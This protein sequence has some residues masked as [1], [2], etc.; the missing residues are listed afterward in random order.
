M[1][2]SVNR[3]LAAT[4]MFVVLALP[5]VAAHA[6]ELT[7][8]TMGGD[9]PGWVKWLEAVA[10]NYEKAN[11]G[12]K[13]KITYY[14]KNALFTTLRTS[15]RA[16]QGPDVLYTEPDQVD[17]AAAG[18]L[19]PLETIAPWDKIQ[20]WAKDAWTSGGHAWAIPYSY[21]TNEI[22]YN[23]K[24][25]KE[26]GVTIP[27]NGQL[28]Q[29]QFLDLVKKAKAAG[30]EPIVIGAGDRPFTGAYLT[31]ELLLRKL[32]VADYGNL[33]NGKLSWSDP[34]VVQVLRYVK[35][36]VDA[37]ALPKT[38][39]TMNLTDSYQYFFK[40]KGLMFPQ[41]TWYT[42]RAFAPADRGG[43]PADFEVGVMTFPK[44]DGGA[45]DNCRHLAL[46]GGY[47]IAADT[48]KPDQAA[49]FLKAIATPEMG[50]LWTSLNNS[51]SGA[52]YDASKVTSP[53]SAYFVELDKVRGNSTYFI[54]IPN[55]HLTGGCRDAYVQVINKGFPAGLIGVD[56][57]IKEMNKACFK[58]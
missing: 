23:K 25:M 37:G 53:H 32:G 30:M 22:M 14:D 42:Q 48:K 9:Q 51:P 19:K 39:A 7:V 3:L 31:S 6:Q 1:I 35:E 38:F 41:G 36:L 27:P 57:T 56:D 29:A 16:G 15:L 4:A 34:R 40:Q 17:I 13:V 50:V 43:Q 44:M 2:G 8:W 49:N 45:C 21:Y 5:S 11:P 28:T 18:Y 20:P 26:L 24:L 10:A 33:L 46:S 52:L 58:G 12:S 54:G 47:A 55:Q